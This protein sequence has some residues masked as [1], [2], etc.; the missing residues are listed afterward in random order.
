[1]FEDYFRE[2]AQILARPGAPDQAAIV[3]LRRRYDTEQVSDWRA[4]ASL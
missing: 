4:G 3:D 2:L 1:L